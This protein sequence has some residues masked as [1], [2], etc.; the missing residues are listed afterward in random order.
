MLLQLRH[1]GGMT[2]LNGQ[3][4]VFSG[5]RVLLHLWL[6]GVKERVGGVALPPPGPLRKSVAAACSLA[7][8]Y[9]TG[10]WCFGNGLASRMNGNHGYSP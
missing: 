2:T 7:W 1:Q 4:T 10:L 6:K 8:G 5:G 3:D 9:A